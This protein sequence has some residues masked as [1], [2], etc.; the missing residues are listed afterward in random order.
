M[1]STALQGASRAGAGVV[2]WVEHS[3]VRV[4]LRRPDPEKEGYKID[5]SERTLRELNWVLRGGTDLKIRTVP[6]IPLG[7]RLP[8]SLLETNANKRPKG[9]L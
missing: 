9:V 8:P 1:A 5:N 4:C 2:Q 6:P 7:S 3:L